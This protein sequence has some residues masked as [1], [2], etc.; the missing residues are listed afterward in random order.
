MARPLRIEFPGALYHVTAR[1]NERKPIYRDAWDWLPFLQRLAGV[2]E[3][4]KLA[5]PAYVLMRNH[6]HLQTTPS[7]SRLTPHKLQLAVQLPLRHECGVSR[8]KP[9]AITTASTKPAD[10][11]TLKSCSLTPPI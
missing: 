3:T 6:Y 11:I 7:T 4:H 2:V 5:V 10:R 8:C 1:G 9:A